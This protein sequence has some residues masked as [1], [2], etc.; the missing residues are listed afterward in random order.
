M[1]GQMVSITKET[2]KSI[3]C[4]AKESC[5]GPMDDTI[6]DSSI[7]ECAT[8]MANSHSLTTVATRANSA[9]INNTVMEC[10]FQAI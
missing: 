5:S 3:R 7:S 2:G 6:K 9:S 10:M 1:N 4:M 8:D